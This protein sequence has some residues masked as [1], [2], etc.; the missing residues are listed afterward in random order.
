LA[1]EGSI[2]QEKNTLTEQEAVR[3]N[4]AKAEEKWVRRP[5][6]VPGS[7]GRDDLGSEPAN[8]KGQVFTIWLDR[9]ELLRYFTYLICGG[10]EFQRPKL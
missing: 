5:R 1:R 8:G 10:G 3:G 2:V 4:D 9:E 6:R 7:L